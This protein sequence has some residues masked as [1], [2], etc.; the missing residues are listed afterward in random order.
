MI[1]LK[2]HTAIGGLALATALLAG[3]AI[4]RALGIS[5]D[6][7]LYLSVVGVIGIAWAVN[8]LMLRRKHDVAEE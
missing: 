6:E 2:P 4:G 1:H 8:R 5:F 7:A 3:T